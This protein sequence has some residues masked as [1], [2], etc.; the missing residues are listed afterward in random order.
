M[1]ENL[2][3]DRA[4]KVDMRQ[5]LGDS[6]F[7]VSPQKDLYDFRLETTPDLS[8]LVP[9]FAEG[10]EKGA[11]EGRLPESILENKAETDSE[12]QGEDRY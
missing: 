9:A 3:T 7:P 8:V 2:I 10:L 12:K 1:R 6:P 11:M 5:I 4:F